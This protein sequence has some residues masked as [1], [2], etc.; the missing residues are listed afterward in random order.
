MKINPEALKERIIAELLEQ[1]FEIGKE[2]ATKDDYRRLQE[3]SK[4]IFLKKYK[5]FIERYIF[6]AKNY[7][8]DGKDLNP[9][10]IDLELK[11]ID[12][13]SIEFQLHK[14]W[15]LV[16]WSMRFQPPVGRVIRFFL[17]DKY[18]QAYFGL[19]TLTSPIFNIGSRDKYLGL[20]AEN[21]CEGVNRSL[22]AHRVGAFPPYNILLGGKMV[23]YTLVSNELRNIATQI[24][25]DLRLYYITTTSAFGKSSIYNRLKFKDRLVGFPVGFTQGYGSFQFTEE[26]YQLIIRFLKENSLYK[27]WKSSSKLRRIK[28]ALRILD[29]EGAS[30]HG[31]KREVYLFPLVENLI[32][33]IQDKESPKYLDYP[34]WELL[35]FWKKRWCVPRS[36]R[37]DS[38]KY[39]NKEQFIDE[40]IKSL[41]LR[42]I[43]F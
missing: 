33:T 22:S 35:N 14:W 34:F 28:Q 36:S 12:S 40:V 7:M 32:E 15:D 3:V 37:V 17:F 8:L 13:D 19:I 31:L 38:W 4:K 10:K 24:Y 18:H 21:Y 41:H 39:F 26:T 16:W 20:T 6:T 5:D 27:D 30:I 2:V 25:P 42:R 1:G 23:A 43:L 29:L 9:T 11:Y